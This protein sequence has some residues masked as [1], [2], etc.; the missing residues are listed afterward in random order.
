MK[1]RSGVAHPSVRGW[2]GSR[3][4]H[5]LL[6][7]VAA[8][9]R[10]PVNPPICPRTCKWVGHP[11]VAVIVWAAFFLAGPAFAETRDLPQAEFRNRLKGGF[12]G[13]MVGVTYAAPYEFRYD[14]TIIPRPLLLPWWPT[15]I[16]GGTRG[17]ACSDR[18]VDQV[19]R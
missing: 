18:P 17:I 9:S 7:L 3:V 5:I 12:V 8:F 13:Q 2:V 15:R 19:A 14:G 10:K 1:H 4:S 11:G 6:R 16:A